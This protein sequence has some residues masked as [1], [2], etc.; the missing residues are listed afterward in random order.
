METTPWDLFIGVITGTDRLHHFLFDAARD[1]N[2]PF[3]A[4]FMEYYRRIDL[5]FGRF[6]ERSGGRTRLIVLSDHGFTRLKTQ[7]YL[8]HLLERMGRLSFTRS[9]PR[10]IEDVH[11]ASEAFAMD[12][13]RIYL[14]SRD[15]FRDGVLDARQKLESRSR[16]KQ[17]LERVRLRDVGIDDPEGAD[18]PDDFL[19]TE[20]RP[21]EA[22]YD[23]A[24]LPMAP[25]LL[26]LPRRGYDLKATIGVRASSMRDIFTGAHTHDDAFLIVND[27]YSAIC[28]THAKIEQVADLIRQVLD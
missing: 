4:D 5:F 25:D 18:R 1:P 19:F 20:V 3:F 15:R 10:S 27:P 24:C 16:L 23:G 2:H 17:D 22:V 28:P 21:K 12:P 8:N 9:N 6:V 26:L 14:N 11:P 7:V 13:N